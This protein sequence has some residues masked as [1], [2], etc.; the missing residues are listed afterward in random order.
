MLP[1]PPVE[2]EQLKWFI[3]KWRIQSRYCTDRES[4]RWLEE[5]A[6]SVVTPILSGHALRET[7]AGMLNGSPVEGVS[8]RTYNPTI[9]RW[10]QCWKDTSAAGF[11]EYTGDY[12]DGM[13]IGISN[14]SFS[15]AERK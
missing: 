12:K 7:F 3:G 10:E 4:D 1:A 14:S 11:A 5:E 9:S 2:T 15:D 6:A 8:M 13:F